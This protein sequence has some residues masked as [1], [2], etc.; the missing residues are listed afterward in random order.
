M[1][2]LSNAL[3]R[4]LA[5]QAGLDARYFSACSHEEARAAVK[6]IQDYLEARG[7]SFEGRQLPVSLR[8]TIVSHGDIQ[9]TAADL[10]VVRSALSKLLDRLVADLRAGLDTEL[11]RFFN[12]YSRWFDLIAGESRR[13]PHVMLMRYDAVQTASTGFK[14]MEPNGACP[15]G[16]IHCAYIRDAWK[17]TSIGRDI[18]TGVECVER[19]CDS[20]DG[21]LRLLYQ[22]AHPKMDP[23][24][25]LCNYRGVFTN[26]LSSLKRRNAILKQEGEV[27]GEVIVCDIEEIEVRGDTAFVGDQQIDVVYNKIDHLMINPSDP[28]IAGWIEA[29][30]LESCEFLNSNAALYIAEAKSIFAALW[31]AGVRDYLQLTPSQIRAIEHRIPRTRM[32]RGRPDSPSYTDLIHERQKYVLKAD[33]L[34]RGAGVHVGRLETADTWGEALLNLASTNAV[35]QDVLDVPTRENVEYFSAG[36]NHS[37]SLHQEF[38]GVDFFFFR[39]RFAGVV[40]RC[41]GSMVFNV[42][43]GGK[44]VPTFVAAG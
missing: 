14:V 1:N 39:D 30:R 44:E 34:T 40:G 32:L 37:G 4:A 16:V 9:N 11:V 43:S 35:I 26:E 19:E 2:V 23:T 15:G 36:A 12:F 22:A 29:S 38:W 21:F 20:P 24:I 5:N 25:A 17:Q 27:R 31:D 18:L 3:H 8:P 42:G 28:A 10:T 41:H 13:N 7:I 33:A 6:G